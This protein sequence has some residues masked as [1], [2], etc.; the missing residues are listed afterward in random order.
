MAIEACVQTGFVS[1]RV[2]RLPTE[3]D[4]LAMVSECED[5]TPLDSRV[6]ALWDLRGLDVDEGAV[7]FVRSMFSAAERCIPGGAPKTALVADGE[8]E[9][10]IGALF[11]A[12]ATEQ[13]S[14]VIR[15]F[16]DSDSAL[17]W[18]LDPPH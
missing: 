4:L 13:M 15:V 7:A 16:D 3:R 11:E 6:P 17:V 14:A 18:L 10:E 8:L 12:L 5:R 2:R 1:F 9:W